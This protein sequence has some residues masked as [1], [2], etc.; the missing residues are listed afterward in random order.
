MN[1]YLG[2]HNRVT[3]IKNVHT[4]PEYRAAP[5]PWD[6]STGSLNPAMPVCEHD[7]RHFMIRLA[8]LT[9]E[10]SKPFRL[11]HLCE[12]SRFQVHQDVWAGV[13]RSMQED[14]G[15]LLLLFA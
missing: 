12:P 7:T 14:N 3:G 1:Q 5:W 4:L 11:S 13:P 15:P 8:S 9:C 6:R 10:F 2:P